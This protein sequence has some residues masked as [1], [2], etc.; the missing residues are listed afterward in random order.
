M[1]SGRVDGID[2]DP[3]GIDED[4]VFEIAL[5]SH[6]TSYSGNI[7]L[8]LR[9]N[10]LMIE[11]D[12]FHAWFLRYSGQVTEYFMARTTPCR[13]EFENENFRVSPS[14]PTAL[15]GNVRVMINPS[16]V[17]PFSNERTDPPWPH[18]WRGPFS[19]LGCQCLPRGKYFLRPQLV[20][21]FTIMPCHETRY[22]PLPLSL[23]PFVFVQLLEWL[24]NG[25]TKVIHSCGLF[26]GFRFQSYDHSEGESDGKEDVDEMSGRLVVD[27][28]RV[29]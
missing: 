13:P 23:V 3:F 18:E 1:L 17:Y 11:R 10:T 19:Y 21:E 29:G 22:S 8:G 26:R 15:D 7:C 6:E 16:Q 25:D 28:R 14:V 2:S 27:L 12:D 9:E 24:P 4:W 5:L 20:N